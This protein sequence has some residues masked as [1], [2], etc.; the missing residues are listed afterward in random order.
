MRRFAS[1][2]M[3]GACLCLLLTATGPPA[4]ADE[5]GEL[6]ADFVDV[7][8][9]LES[10]GLPTQPVWSESELGP[11]D[12]DPLDEACPDGYFPEYEPTQQQIVFKTFRRSPLG[13]AINIYLDQWDP[14]L[15]GGTSAPAVVLYHG[16]GWRTGCRRLLQKQAAAFADAGYIVF[17]ADY[18]LSCSPQDDPH[19]DEAPLCGWQYPT[20]D[21]ETGTPGA[22]IHDVQDAV[23]WVKDHADEYWSVFNGKVAAAGGS[24][25]GNLLYRGAGELSANDPRR[26]DVVSGWSGNAHF[27]EMSSGQLYCNGAPTPGLRGSCWGAVI[28]YIGCDIRDLPDTNCRPKY[29]AAQPIDAYAASGPPAFIANSNDE[30]VNILTAENLRDRLSIV[31][32]I[33]AELCEVDGDIHG[34][35]YVLNEP[36][37]DNPPDE[38][39]VFDSMVDFFEPYVQP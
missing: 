12:A 6:P 21:V 32:G 17:S 2:V 15:P 11:E 22:A 38:P 18:R 26:P 33:D 30:L 7:I 35:G 1:F 8:P 29:L 20:I 9:L 16:G 31:L 10:L 36:C 5:W 23:A 14:E 25:G 37:I 24:A 19:P 3:T 27:A 28:R 4:T 13:P 39:L 34:R